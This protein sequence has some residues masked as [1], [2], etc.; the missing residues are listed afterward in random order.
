MIRSLIIQGL[1]GRLPEQQRS[2]AE[3]H[4]YCERL[5]GIAPPHDRLR[6]VLK[7]H[8]RL[9]EPKSGGA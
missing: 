2:L 3:D 1:S 8:N 4:Q 5:K 6:E 9:I 7:K